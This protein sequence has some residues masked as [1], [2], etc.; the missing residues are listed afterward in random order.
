MFKKL[1]HAVYKTSEFHE[2]DFT[3]GEKYRI[4]VFCEKMWRSCREYK[5]FKPS[6]KVQAV[7]FSRKP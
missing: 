7:L 4:V 5:I 6:L 3:N 1:R 2:R